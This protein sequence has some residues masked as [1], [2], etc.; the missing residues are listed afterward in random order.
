MRIC[1]IH[2]AACFYVSGMYFQLGM[3]FWRKKNMEYCIFLFANLIFNFFGPIYIFWWFMMY[4]WLCEDD[5]ELFVSVMSVNLSMAASVNWSCML[6][7]TSSVL[8]LSCPIMCSP[9]THNPPRTETGL[10]RSAAPAIM[11]SLSTCSDLLATWHE[12]FHP[13]LHHEAKCSQLLL[14]TL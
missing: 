10:G 6:L 4:L 2:K 13:H 5:V 3:F 8:L 1:L 9:A 12:M 14:T 7:A 11:A